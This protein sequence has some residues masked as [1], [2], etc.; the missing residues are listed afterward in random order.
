M[1][2]VVGRLIFKGYTYM[3]TTIRQGLMELQFIKNAAVTDS[4]SV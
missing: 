1:G 4:S 2:E 3:S